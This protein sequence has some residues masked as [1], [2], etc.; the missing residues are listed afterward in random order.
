[1]KLIDNYKFKDELAC[2][3]IWLLGVSCYHEMCYVKEQVLFQHNSKSKLFEHTK[4]K[5]I[6]KEK[7]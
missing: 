1:M 7:S 4:N 5:K 3:L 6:K 2:S